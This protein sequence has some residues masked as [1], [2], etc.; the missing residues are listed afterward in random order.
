MAL[1]EPKTDD[2]QHDF[3]GIRFVVAKDEKA[4]VFGRSGVSIDY[5]ESIF[6]GGFS[7]RSSDGTSGCC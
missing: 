5:K 7:I 1:D 4:Q 6:G 3:K 2:I